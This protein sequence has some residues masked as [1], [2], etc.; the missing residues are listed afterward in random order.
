MPG[1]KIDIH[2]AA[3]EGNLGEVKAFLK[4]GGIIDKRDPDRW[5]PLM[6][7][8]REGHL[9]VAKQ[10]L[11]SGA[12][13]EA[14]DGDKWTAMHVA[15]ANGHPQCCQLLLDRGANP[16]ATDE[17]KRTP[18]HWA[19]RRALYGYA[20]VVE[21]LLKRGADP[22]SKDAEEKTPGDVI[23]NDLTEDSS[24]I[25]HNLLREHAEKVKA[26]RQR[27]GSCPA[28]PR[29]AM[30]A[31]VNA[32]NGSVG[33]S[34]P[35]A[36]SSSTSP[37]KHSALLPLPNVLVAR[38]DLVESSSNRAELPPVDDSGNAGQPVRHTS[39]SV[40]ANIRDHPTADKPQ[41]RSV[42]PVLGNAEVAAPS[43]LPQSAKTGTGPSIP[44]SGDSRH[45]SSS[46]GSRKAS[47][48]A[49]EEGTLAGGGGGTL[50]DEEREGAGEDVGDWRGE[51]ARLRL[52][53][54]RAEE[55]ARLSERSLSEAEERRLGE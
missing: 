12:A 52:A 6:F 7:A 31:A 35:E 2:A 10:L 25:V 8:V 42:K 23:G 22:N 20:A 37:K 51:V 27:R 40:A 21:L 24:T 13:L 36:A 46:K 30:I 38:T 26:N 47:G 19:T 45:A 39:F 28:I 3:G 5:T 1:H 34:A 14:K 43:A 15:A 44:A 29:T 16:R 11:R 18:L 49:V 17:N 54:E 33:A 41:G 50:H 48:D 53:L 55:R 32:S 4:A 9:E